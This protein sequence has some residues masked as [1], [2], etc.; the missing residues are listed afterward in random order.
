MDVFYNEMPPSIQTI[1]SSWKHNDTLVAAKVIQSTIPPNQ[2]NQAVHKAQQIESKAIN[3]AKL[4]IQELIDCDTKHNQGCI[5]G[6]PV[7]AFP[8]IHKH[9][10]V[11]SNDYPYDGVQNKKCLDD[12]LPP[13]ATTNSWGVLKAKDESTVEYALRHLGPISVGFNGGDKAFLLYSGGIFDSK[14][15]SNHPNH[16]MLITGY[17]EEEDINGNTVSLHKFRTSMISLHSNY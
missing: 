10:L 2:L 1:S 3:L 15:C 7:M 8:Y 9:G 6:N 12:D 16:A 13:I 5:G 11:S 4:S 17:G 14:L